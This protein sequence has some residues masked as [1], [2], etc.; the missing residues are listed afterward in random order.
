MTNDTRIQRIMGWKKK[1]MWW[2]D[3][4]GG[5]PDSKH[6]VWHEN[7]VR[8]DKGPPDYLNDR[9]ALHTGLMGMSPD[10]WVKFSN[11][12]WLTFNEHTSVPR[13]IMQTLKTPLA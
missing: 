7:G 9:N 4:M 12:L 3:G 5:S 8:K 1:P 11:G 2:A 6:M 10:E 13:V